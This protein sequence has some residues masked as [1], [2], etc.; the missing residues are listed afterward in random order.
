M[1]SRFWVFFRFQDLGLCYKAFS[2]ILYVG[3]QTKPRSDMEQTD[4]TKLAQTVR[5]LLTNN[6]VRPPRKLS[7]VY[8]VLKVLNDKFNGV[9]TPHSVRTFADEYF[10]CNAHCLS[11]G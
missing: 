8:H 10:T 7:S 3:T 11:C 9:I 1:K 5:N 6:S 4:F 2:S